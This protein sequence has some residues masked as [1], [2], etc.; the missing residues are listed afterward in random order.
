MF[1]KYFEHLSRILSKKQCDDIFSLV[2]ENDGNNI[3][4]GIDDR[5]GVSQIPS[6]KGVEIN[7]VG[8]ENIVIFEYGSGKIRNSKIIIGSKN[9]IFI[10]K[11]KFRLEGINIVSTTADECGLI[12]DRNFS[13]WKCLIQLSEKKCVQ[14]GTNVMFGPDVEIRTSDFHAIFDENGKV[15]NFGKDVIIDDHVWIGTRVL[16]M[17]GAQISAN[18]VVGAGAIVTKK[19]LENGC[20]I[21]GIPAKVCKNNIN[22]TRSNPDLYS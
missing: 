19:F 7:F 8:N 21:V 20:L 16:L 5:G 15:I 11:T 3:I 12:I 22:W 10:G 9:L 17:K 2:Q 14:I 1:I 18:S 13:C 4:I 6:I